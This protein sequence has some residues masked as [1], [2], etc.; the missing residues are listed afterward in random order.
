MLH[1][2]RSDFPAVIIGA[3]PA[4]LASSRELARLGIDHVVLE[5]GTIGESWSS[6]V[7]DSLT[8][9]TGKHMSGL[10]GRPIGRGPMFVPRLAFVDYLRRYHAEFRLPVRT[11]VAV[12]A[13]RPDNRRYVIETTAGELRTDAVIVAAGIISDPVAPPLPG[14]ETFRGRLRHSCTYRR[15]DE[16][17]GRRVLV[18]GAGNSA[19]EIASELG[20][21]GVDTT[22][23]IRSG[24]NVVPLHI[25]GI[26]I[27][28]FSYLLRM[29]PRRVQ[30][31][32]IGAMNRA[33]DLIKG[34]PVI[35]RGRSS[36]LDSIPMIGFHLTDAIREGIVEVRGP[37]RHLT[38]T[39]AVFQ[40][41]AEE[42][43]DE[44]I[45]AT[46]FRAAMQ[47]LGALV[48]RDEKGF[49]S[50]RDRVRSADHDRLFFVGHN[51]DTTGALFNIRRDAKLAASAVKSALASLYTQMS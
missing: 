24:A 14:Q 12:T 50:R 51:Y 28:Y 6:R 1:P 11:G 49:A 26:P 36:A 21:S 29:L 42:S 23:S 8:L 39:G 20:R 32:V 25:L 45:L 9:H 47:F 31:M 5:R 15:P 18:I 44:I 38:A 37:I 46:G 22:I 3:G 13:I 33:T 4:G 40:D 7:Y 16:C 48:T 35:P 19:G 2:Q 43:F 27:Q 17:R 34:P 41:G 10:P 30:E